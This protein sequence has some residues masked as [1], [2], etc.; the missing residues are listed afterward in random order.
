MTRGLGKTVAALRIQAPLQ[1][2]ALD[3]QGAG[4]HTVP[5]PQGGVPD[6]D[7]HGRAGLGGVVG[8][9]RPYPLIAAAHPLQQRVDSD[10]LAH[11]QSSGRSTCSRRRT[12]PLRL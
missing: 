7:Q 10:R 3:H 5:F 6:V 12:W 11:C 8:V 1:L 4:D 9:A 2:V